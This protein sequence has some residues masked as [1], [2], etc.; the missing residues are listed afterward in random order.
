VAEN[1]GMWRLMKIISNENNE[2]KY[3]RKWRN[4]ESSLN[5]LAKISAAASKKV[6][7]MAAAGVG[8]GESWQY[9]LASKADF[10][11]MAGEMA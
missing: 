4:N 1:G 5:W 7:I 9:L 3:H 10:V 11:A 2:S 8:S 6:K